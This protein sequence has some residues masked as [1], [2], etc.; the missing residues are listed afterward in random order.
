LPDGIRFWKSYLETA[1]A[2]PTRSVG[3]LYGPSGCGKSS[4]VKAG[5]L[6]RLAGHVVAVYVE[7]APDETESRLLKGLCQRC[8]D[9]SRDLDLPDALAHLRRGHGP[10]P[11]QKV[12]LVLDQFEQWLHARR[13]ERDPELVRALRQCDGERVQCVVLV[14]DD[15]WLAVSR[16]LREVEVRLIEGHNATLVDLFDPLHARKVL[17]DFGRAFGRLPDRLGQLSG[18]QERFLDQAVSGLAQ[19]GKVVSVRLSLFA[20]MVKGKP[21]TPATLKEMGGT[22]GIG[23]TFLEETFSART[24]PPEHRLHQQAARS[25]LQ[26]LLPEPGTDL[27]GHM[28]S[29]ADLLNASGY[30]ERPREFDDVLRILD[31]ELRLV[32]P[33][34]PEGVASEKPQA[35][36]H[37]GQNYQLTHDYLVPSLREWLTRKQRET[38]RGRA[39]LHLAE[40]TAL[41]KSRPER[42]QLPTWWEWTQIQLFTNKKDWTQPQRAMMRMATNWVLLWL[43]LSL[44]F[45]CFT[46]YLA[47][48]MFGVFRSTQLLAG[49]TSVETKDV[50][51]LVQKLPRYRPWA[52]PLFNHVLHKTTP[53]S[54]AHLHAS[55][56]LVPVDPGQVNY[57]YGR[58]LSAR[59]D[60]L[61]V[62]RDSLKEYGPVLRERLW[63]VVESPDRD[64]PSRLRAA[65]ALASY[66]PDSR[67]WDTVRS[68]VADQLVRENAIA[69][70]QWW[71]ETLRPAAG[72]L[73]EPLRQIMHDDQRHESERS[74]AR[75]L[76]VNYGFLSPQPR[77]QASD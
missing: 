11:G 1:E 47:Y 30:A 21:W 33:V 73:K 43:F 56:A 25:V 2:D 31:A 34:D 15:F 10:P 60:E 63:L 32:T 53:E 27:K 35:T 62:I 7:A 24:A 59:P 64:G 52:D 6:P 8:P 28:R 12:V 41:W 61:L 23:V 9:L 67:R 5:L 3:L 68:V 48:D 36:I 71:A 55:L 50:P 4:F 40:R 18:E 42:R 13:E 69:V 51:A 49:L 22:E 77:G 14:R 20:E 46:G 72:H 38:R 19:D 75:D 44:E 54:R 74:L 57:L 16:F 45:L 58:L 37:G 17:A 26:A 39:E 70:G 65:C 76:L 29:R 66:D